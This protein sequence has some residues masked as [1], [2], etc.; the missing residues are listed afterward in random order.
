MN[1]LYLTLNFE[2]LPS[3]ALC[4]LGNPASRQLCPGI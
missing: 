3:D 1:D 2:D 4:D